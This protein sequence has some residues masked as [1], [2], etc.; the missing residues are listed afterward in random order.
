MD[1]NSGSVPPELSNKRAGG[2]TGEPAQTETRRNPDAIRKYV[3]RKLSFD[4]SNQA[5][6]VLTLEAARI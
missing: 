2:E 6:K 1:G 3:S 4:H 5:L